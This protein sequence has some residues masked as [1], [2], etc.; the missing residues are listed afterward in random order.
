MR[1]ST[2][3]KIRRNKHAKQNWKN[4]VKRRKLEAKGQ[5]EA[6]VE[7]MGQMVPNVD[8]GAPEFEQGPD[9]VDFSTVKIRREKVEY[10]REE[11]E[12]LKRLQEQSKE[13]PGSHP[14]DE[15]LISIRVNLS[16]QKASLFNPGYCG[17]KPADN[18]GI[19]QEGNLVLPADEVA[20][21]FML[22]NSAL[23]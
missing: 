12:K 22:R 20:V 10:S 2:N 1:L 17:G 13:N 8:E 16:N 9:D 15:A 18:C 6:N 23:K 4:K 14:F 21:S 19:L 7:E 3:A 11:E 5:T